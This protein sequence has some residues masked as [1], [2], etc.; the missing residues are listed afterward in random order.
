MPKVLVVDDSALDRRLAS[1][2]LEQ[3]PADVRAAANGLEA[4]EMIA[5]EAP[6]VVVTD[7]QMP[8]L[9]G[10]GLVERVRNEYPMLPVIL[11]TAFGSEET[12]VRALQLGAASYVPKDKLS[13]QLVET[14]QSI[15]AVSLPHDPDP[16]RLQSLVVSRSRFELKPTLRDMDRAIAYI[17]DDLRRLG[18]CGEADMVRVG[19]ALHEAIVNGTEH[20]NLEVSSEL[21]EQDATEF[22]ELVEQ[23]S[24]QM[25]F[26]G[27]RVELVAQ[28]TRDEARFTVSDEGPGF[29]PSNLPDPTA[30]EN[31]G[32]VS[33]RGVFL[34]RTFMDEVF[35]NEK[36][37]T[38]TM[39]K[40]RGA[41]DDTTD[42]AAG[43]G[44]GGANGAPP[45]GGEAA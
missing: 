31:I 10:F 7:I 35:F 44:N 18:V 2:I 26:C 6:D 17:Q 41:E 40:R 32:K 39:I 33:G 21:R 27:R 1:S 29:D 20:G 38:I 5:E 37:T 4:M 45:E 13:E 19:T 22:R 43:K 34:I 36:G 8:K 15:L 28:I 11:M 23:R 16:N 9:D 24:R 14:V 42:K 12:A 25:P 30:P 3:M